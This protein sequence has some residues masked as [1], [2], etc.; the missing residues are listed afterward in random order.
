ML[1]FYNLPIP[2]AIVV[3][4]SLVLTFQWAAINL[5]QTKHET[6]LVKVLLAISIDSGI[7]PLR[8]YLTLLLMDLT[9]RF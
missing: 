9:L 5:P 7:C 2:D 3:E 1:T 4:K 6:F 8:G